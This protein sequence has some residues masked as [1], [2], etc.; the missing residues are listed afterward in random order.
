MNQFW[1]VT[2]QLSVE[3]NDRLQKVREQYLVSAVSATDAEAKITKEFSGHSNF[4]V[5]G[6][7]QSKII[8]VI[9]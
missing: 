7:I 2:V 8:K 1:T 6:V 3:K 9:E 5:V 4:E